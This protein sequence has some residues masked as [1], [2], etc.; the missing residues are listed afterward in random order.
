MQRLAAG[1]WKPGERLPSETE[2]AERFG[3]AVFTV[4]A[5]IQ[6]LVDAGILLRRQGKG[7]YVALHRTRPLRNQF[8]RI[9]SNDGRKASWD[10]HLISVEK[11]RATDTVAEILR[12]GPTAADRAIYDVTF[13]LQDDGKNVAFV[14]SKMVAKFFGHVTEAALK[15]TENLYAVFQERF[16]V[17]VVSIDERVKAVLAGKSATRWL[18]VSVGDPL[19]RTER[20][21]Y[22][23]NEVPVELRVYNVRADDYYYFS[24]PR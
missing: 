20:I 17:N 19:L 12:L 16:G 14:E 1:E 10:R 11:S 21:A 7:T 8:L 18:G 2:L 9:Y 13:L 22:T 3:V 4:R 6:K 5:G 23:Y 24:P 15:S